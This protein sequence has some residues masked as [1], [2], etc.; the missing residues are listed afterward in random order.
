MTTSAQ[1]RS[2]FN[3]LYTKMSAGSDID[4]QLICAVVVQHHPVSHDI[5]YF[6]QL[7]AQMIAITPM[8]IM[9]LG[10]VYDAESA[11]QMIRDEN[12]ISMIPVRNRESLISRTKGKY[13]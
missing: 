2:I 12:V 6:P 1:L 10:K 5:K 7:F 4:S 11:H 8:W 3:Y 13:R 9:V